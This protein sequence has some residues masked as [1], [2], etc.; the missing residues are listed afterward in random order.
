M[1]PIC[2][3]DLLAAV[4][5]IEQK[6]LA[7]P[8]VFVDLAECVLRQEGWQRSTT[9]AE[10]KELYLKLVTRSRLIVRCNHDLIS[11]FIAALPHNIVSSRQL[12]L[13]SNT[14]THSTDNTIWNR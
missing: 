3:E 2:E 11:M 14:S 5:Y 4:G 8:Q 12:I 1:F 6:P 7:V 13:H 10:A 9:A